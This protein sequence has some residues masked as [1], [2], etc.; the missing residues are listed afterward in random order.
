MQSLLGYYGG[1][2][3]AVGRWIANQIT[4]IP[5]RNRVEPYGGMFSV[6]L[7]LDPPDGAEVYND[8]AD[9]LVNLFAVVRDPLT[10]LELQEALQWTLF[11]RREYKRCVRGQHAAGISDVER[12]RRT[13]V[14][15]AQS[16]DCSV[17]HKGW[18]HAGAK[19]RGNVADTFVSGQARIPE[20]G[21]R[22]R[23]VMIEH[24]DAN[25]IIRQW[26]AEDT[27]FYVDS[28]YLLS[29]RNSLGYI[30]EMND[31]E[32]LAH[33][34][35]VRACR[36]M[37]L[38]SGYASEM[39]ARELESNGWRR[40]EF[41]TVAHSSASNAKRLNAARVECLWLNPAAMDALEQPAFG[42]FASTKQ[43]VLI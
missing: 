4:Q 39:Y 18:R 31:A 20:V 14:V 35:T 41:E 27:L 37:V 28:P 6:S 42:L 30:H 15:I 3:G 34:A 40:R 7:R 9:V 2:S 1:K 26:D 21:E 23:N 29:K 11:S 8:K 24:A 17:L 22:L 12:A 43:E 38:V 19:Y 33:L 13:Y 32:H 5:H 36:G 10:R 25:S 16:R